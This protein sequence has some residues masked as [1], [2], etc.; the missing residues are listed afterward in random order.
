MT[1]ESRNSVTKEAAV[2]MQQQI[3][4]HSNRNHGK[5]FFY[6]VQAEAAM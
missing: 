6:T 5:Y 4:L 3:C 2:A 1:A